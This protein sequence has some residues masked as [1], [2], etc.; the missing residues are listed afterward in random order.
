MSTANVIPMPGAALT[1]PVQ[2]NNRGPHPKT[3]FSLRRRR[4]KKNGD[5]Y[6]RK[7]IAAEVEAMEST[8]KVMRGVLADMESKMREMDDPHLTADRRDQ[9]AAQIEINI[10]RC[11]QQNARM[12]ASPN[13]EETTS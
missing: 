11:N 3:V 5:E 8:L 6:K 12:Y 13:T 1:P 4:L 2:I 7:L 10:R 9:F